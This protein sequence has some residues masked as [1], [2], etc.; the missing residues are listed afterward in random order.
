MWRAAKKRPWCWERLRA[1][2]ERQRMRCLD[3]RPGVLRFMGSQWVR[4]DW[5]IELNWTSFFLAVAAVMSRQSC[6]TPC[7]PVDG[8]PPGSSGPGILQ[9][10][11]LEWVAISFSKAW[12]WKVKVNLLSLS[13]AIS[14][15]S[16]LFPSSI[17]HTFWP[18]GSSSNLL[19]FHNLHCILVA[20]ILEWFAISSSSGPCFVRTLHYDLS[21]LHSLA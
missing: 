3:G 20:R 16:P 5:A 6:P 17:F 7:N 9:T 11:T 10:R 13:G 1:G 8:S 14:N 4:R 15:C 2:R 19:S 21:I 12:K 18:G